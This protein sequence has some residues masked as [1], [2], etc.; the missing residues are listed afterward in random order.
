MSGGVDAWIETIRWRPKSLE[1]SAMSDTELRDLLL[2]GVL[3]PPHPGGTAGV[4]AVRRHHRGA[5]GGGDRSDGGRH[6]CGFGIAILIGAMAL[7]GINE[8]SDGACAS[9]WKQR[10]STS[11]A[12]G[13]SRGSG[14]ADLWEVARVQRLPQ[15][16]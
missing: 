12:C 8:F 11:N 1:L 3:Q 6:A 14:A 2:S 13:W 7:Y 15:L 4:P 9:C 10:A 5:S 16:A